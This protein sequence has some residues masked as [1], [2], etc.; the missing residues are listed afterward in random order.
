MRSPAFDDWVAR[1]READML[2][3]ATRLGAKLKRA[4]REWVGPCPGCGGRDR[5]G[6]NPQKR[7]F[8]CRGAAGGDSI[9]M[10]EH[11]LGYDFRGAVRRVL[12]AMQEATSQR[13]RLALSTRRIGAMAG[14][15]HTTVRTAI[16]DLEAR[17]RV[18]VLRRGGSSSAGDPGVYIVS[19][20][21]Q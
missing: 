4:G 3:V 14:V 5:F 17:G 10:V 18:T 12:A 2:S 8:V 7:V 11:V 1:A 20:Q 19:G 13:G 15:S 21:P 6:I 16:A 9:T